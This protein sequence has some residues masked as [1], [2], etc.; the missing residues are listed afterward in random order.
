MKHI[1]K[2][3]DIFGSNFLSTSQEKHIAKLFVYKFQNIF[4]L[5]QV[6]TQYQELYQKQF[7]YKA[8][9]QLLFR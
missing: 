1:P 5:K 8:N 6:L 9:K 3:T 2:F 7:L 4:L